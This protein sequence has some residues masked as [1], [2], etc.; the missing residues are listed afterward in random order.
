[1][2]FQRIFYADGAHDEIPVG[3]IEEAGDFLV[4]MLGTAEVFRVNQ[5]DVAAMED[6]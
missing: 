6:R 2:E 3:S 4:F 1:M 5:K